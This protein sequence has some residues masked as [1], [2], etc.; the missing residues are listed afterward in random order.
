ALCNLLMR[1]NVAP[2][3]AAIGRAI[4]AAR[5][6]ERAE[7]VLID[8]VRGEAVGIGV[9]RAFRVGEHIDFAVR[10][11]ERLADVELG[12]ALA[13]GQHLRGARLHRVPEPHARV[14]TDAGERSAGDIAGNAILPEPGQPLLVEPERPDQA[15]REVADE[16]LVEIARAPD[17]ERPFALAEIE[18]LKPQALRGE[19]L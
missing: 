15:A 4:P 18:P 8:D 11:L 1:E 5:L 16:G 9:R 3:P 17:R 6:A 12:Q 2:V 19:R 10:L 13:P 7:A 14:L